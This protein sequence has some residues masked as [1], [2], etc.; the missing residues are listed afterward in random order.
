VLDFYLALLLSFSGIAYRWLSH[1]PDP[2]AFPILAIMVVLALSTYGQCLFGLDLPDGWQRYRLLP[3]RGWQV[4]LAKDAAFVLLAMVLVAGLDLM[5]GLGAAL[6]ALAVGHH[7]SVNTPV[8]QKRWRFTGGTLFP[9]GL[10]QAVAM[11]GVGV[12]ARR[13]GL[14]YLAPAAL[15]YTGSVWL[16]GRRWDRIKAEE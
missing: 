2:E 12:G 10:L 3:L 7:G 6:A 14:I 5:A 1:S 16:Y 8:P 13:E 9:T 4:L 15:I 11:F